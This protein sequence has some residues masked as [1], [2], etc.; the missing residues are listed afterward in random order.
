MT[1]E[2]FSNADIAELLVKQKLRELVAAYS[3]AADRADEAAM[4]ALFHP[5]SLVDS[6]VIRADG[7]TFA[8]EF[9]RWY[10]ENADALS[11]SV[12][13]SWFVV[14]GSS[15]VGE[16]YV[17]GL[18]RLN[19]VHG[20]KQALTA[21]R[22]LD[23]FACRAGEWRFTERRFIAD[24]GIDLGAWPTETAEA[25]SPGWRAGEDDPVHRLWRTIH[26]T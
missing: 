17:L 23:R 2:T 14:E 4:A 25:D 24:L 15:A 12:C 18:S 6:G 10:R 8:R 11:H 21:G 7:R 26:R 19:A 16:S 13:S 22:Y 9:V 5:E 3:R 20:R 1:A